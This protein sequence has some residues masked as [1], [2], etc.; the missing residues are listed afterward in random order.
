MSEKRIIDRFPQGTIR[1]PPSKSISH[2]AIICASIAEGKSLIS[3]VDLS[4]DIKAT[5]DCMK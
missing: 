4:D 5:I 3:N 1:I 2:R